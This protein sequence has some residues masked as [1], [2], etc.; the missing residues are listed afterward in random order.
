MP[1]K[2]FMDI[3]EAAAGK[4]ALAMSQRLGCSVQLW[5]RGCALAGVRSVWVPGGSKRDIFHKP[6]PL[7]L[8]LHVINSKDV[9]KWRKTSPRNAQRGSDLL[10]QSLRQPLYCSSW[11]STDPHF[12]CL[13][14][15]NSPASQPPTTSTSHESI[16]IKLSYSCVTNLAQNAVKH[17]LSLPSSKY[18]SKRVPT[19]G[20]V[21][22]LLHEM[23]IY[24]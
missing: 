16:G 21:F 20:S 2:D 4:Q 8:C 18:I 24:V 10:S 11:R 19:L 3:Y 9:K 22:V 17:C 5:D 7:F 23:G 6:T 14:G 1:E 13:F 12:L 15:R